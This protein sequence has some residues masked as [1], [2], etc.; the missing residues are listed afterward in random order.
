[1]LVDARHVAHFNKLLENQS[2]NYSPPKHSL[3]YN[4][5]LM[6]VNEYPCTCEADEKTLLLLEEVSRPASADPGTSDCSNIGLGA[7]QRFSGNLESRLYL[8]DGT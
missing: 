2:K 8:S 3:Q 5:T 1:M 4:H 6:S 7:G